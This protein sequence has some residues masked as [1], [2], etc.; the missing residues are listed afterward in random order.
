MTGWRNGRRDVRRVGARRRR[1]G[2]DV[3]GLRRAREGRILCGR[4]T[5]A[6]TARRREYAR[7]VLVVHA[8]S[9]RFRQQIPAASVADV[10][11]HSLLRAVQG[12]V[13]LGY[14]LL[15]AGHT[16]NETGQ[17]GLVRVAQIKDRA[18]A[19]TASS[20]R[21]FF[22][23]FPILIRSSSPVPC[24]SSGLSETGRGNT[25]DLRVRS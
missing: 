6:V 22:P 7:A 5:A 25:N 11:C 4:V 18:Y 13:L 20:C 2:Y 14:K 15:L 3:S 24:S 21:A 19:G 17:L 16:V 9:G 8:A 23:S 10:S 12:H 1:A